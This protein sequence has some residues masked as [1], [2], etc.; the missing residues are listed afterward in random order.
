[1]KTQSI[2]KVKGPSG[3]VYFAYLG[4]LMIMYTYI[5]LH[6]LFRGMTYLFIG[7]TIIN[8]IVLLIAGL[9]TL[10]KPG[11]IRLGHNTITLMDRIVP[12]ENID[13]I[14]IQG[15]WKPVVG[16]RLKGT[17]ILSSNQ[18]CRFLE[19]EDDALKALRQWANLNQVKISN[20]PF[21]R[22]I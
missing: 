21:L 11:D 3:L 10:K 12:V 22:W 18:C 6:G 15:Y 2:F 9:R 16:I 20:R 1:M 13:E 14:I 4:V 7:L 5:S 19:R 8:V 17:K